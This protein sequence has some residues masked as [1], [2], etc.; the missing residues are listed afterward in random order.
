MCKFCLGRTQP[1]C[2]E[3]TESLALQTAQINNLATYIGP[4]FLPFPALPFQKANKTPK[5]KQ[6]LSLDKMSSE[7]VHGENHST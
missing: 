4:S 2:H 6:K 5:L 7:V 1:P 3:S